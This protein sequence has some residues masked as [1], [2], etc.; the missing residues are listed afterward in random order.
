MVWV[1]LVAAFSVHVRALVLAAN[2]FADVVREGVRW[3]AE[4]MIF[5]RALGPSAGRLFAGDFCVAFRPVASRGNVIR[6]KGGE[7]G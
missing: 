4:L 5:R 3:R 2:L 1:V 6:G 7:L